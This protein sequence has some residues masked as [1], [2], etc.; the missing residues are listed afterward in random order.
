MVVAPVAMYPLKEARAE[1]PKERTEHIPVAVL[2]EPQQVQRLD[3]VMEHAPTPMERASQVPMVGRQSTKT[4]HPEVVIRR[5]IHR[6]TETIERTIICSFP[7]IKEPEIPI[8][9]TNVK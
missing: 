5:I 1:I 8:L 7:I 9:V 2:P 6:K 3:L 4:E